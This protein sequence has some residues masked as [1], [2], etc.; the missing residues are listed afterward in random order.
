LFP[1][2]PPPLELPP[3]Q[4]RRLLFN[5]VSSVLAATSAQ[6]PI[7]LLLDDLH[8]A[9]QGT[10]LLLIHLAHL[11]AKLPVLMVGTYRDFELTP[12]KPLAGAL[13][14]LTRL[15]LAEQIALG[16]L[17]RTAV[18]QMLRAL[19]GREP[20]DAVVDVIYTGTE[21]NPFFVEELFQH[22][23]EQG[24]L[25]GP[26]GS[27]RR[28]LQ[29]KD[30]D[31]PQSVRLVIGRRLARLA[32]PTQQILFSA[33]VVGRSFTLDLLEGATGE[34]AERLLD[35]VEEAEGAGLI[36]STIEYPDARFSFGHELI[37]QTVLQSLSGARRQRLHLDVANAMER[38][39]AGVLEDH[40][41]DLAH[42]L[43]QAGALAEPARTLRYLVM[44][45]KRAREQGA[46]AETETLYRQAVGLLGRMPETRERDQQEL[47][48]QLALGQVFVATRGYTAPET[49]AAY[50]RAS[51]L[52]ERLGEPIQVVLALSGIYAS[53]LLRGDMEGTAALADRILAFAQRH[54]SPAPLAWAH[55]LQCAVNYHRGNLARAFEHFEGTKAAY[56]EADHANLPQ[57]PGVES[58]DY[59]AV[60]CWQL[61]RADTARARMRDALALSERLRKPYETVHA[62]FYAAYLHVLM[63][64]PAASL[65]FSEVVTELT[66]QHAI[67]LY[68]EACRILRGW[69]LAEQGHADEGARIASEGVANYMASANRLA[70]GSFLAFLAEARARSGQVQAA[71]ATVEEG[72]RVAP[73]QLVD[74]PYLLWLR[75]E[76]LLRGGA[77]DAAAGGGAE[78][79]QSFRDAIALANSI[80][81]K[82]LALRAATSLGRQFK[83]RGKFAQARETIASLVNGFT[84]GLDTRDLIDAR[85]LLEELSDS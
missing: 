58:L 69:A 27:F 40:A 8:W 63:R 67:P 35:C 41:D 82:S 10:L 38:L 4:S 5:A 24:K 68:L 61:G 32:Q 1:D 70:I 77:G 73:D 25:L 23:A 49:A 62:W 15:H 81:A 7:V 85:R 45:A 71:L 30:I 28:D 55:H 80:G 54:P 39:Y 52:G 76:L 37:R 65:R 18:G 13:D 9:D 43:W 51:A 29:L 50:D 59:A 21:G 3:E 83:S 16:G 17:D 22:L 79:E 26:D 14:E 20:P 12:A 6:T 78:A 75:G 48:L 72:L 42:H 46:L 34:D 33:A 84:E 74:Q 64:E 53:S 31:A 11:I 44:A 2:I 66:E 19:S 36:S 57:D 47:A 60:T 56:R